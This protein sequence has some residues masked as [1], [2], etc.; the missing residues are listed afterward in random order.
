MEL[1]AAIKTK[2][3]QITS[4]LIARLEQASPASSIILP[5]ESVLLR[6]A[7]PEMQ[8]KNRYLRL[9]DAELKQ[10]QESLKQVM[11]ATLEKM[12][13][14]KSDHQ[15]TSLPNLGAV[16]INAT[17]ENV[18]AEQMAQLLSLPEVES[19]LIDNPEMLTEP[20]TAEQ[21]RGQGRHS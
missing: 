18:T 13:T 21:K 20:E 17:V 1:P 19:A 8:R 5:H 12:R 4:Q 11:Q 15:F 3:S 7:Q 14:I 6:I 2:Q 10:R 9:S 16:C